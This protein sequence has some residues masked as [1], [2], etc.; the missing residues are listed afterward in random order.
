MYHFFVKQEQIGENEIFIQGEDVNHI[1]NVLRLKCGEQVIISCMDTA[2]KIDYYCSI[3]SVTESEVIVNI[4]WTEEGRELP[5]KLYLFQSLPK[6]D[7]MELIIQKAVELGVYEIIPV[8]AK[9]CVV[10]IDAKKEASKISR[11]Q[12]IAESAAKQ[13]KRSII[14]QIK[15]VMTMKEAL[16]YAG[17]MD[18]KLMP[19]ENA[20]GIAQTRRIIGDIQREESVAI[21]VGPEGGFEPQEVTDAK[22]A[23]FAPVTLGKRIL[24]TETAGMMMLSVLMYQLEE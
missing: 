2:E 16:A 5:N 23:G 10:K 21:L 9:R 17:G 19:Y 8:A 20:K 7:K 11:W 22:E 12:A 13:S 15:P 18:V 4:D 14:P 1:K 6:S 3:A 24:R